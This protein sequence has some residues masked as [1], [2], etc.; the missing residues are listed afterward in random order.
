MKKVGLVRL[1][2]N[3]KHW[4]RWCPLPRVQ[5]S[6]ESQLETNSPVTRRPRMSQAAS[7]LRRVSGDDPSVFGSLNAP[8]SRK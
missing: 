1:R 3:R 6:A 4:K 5:L 7:D 2:R 8:K